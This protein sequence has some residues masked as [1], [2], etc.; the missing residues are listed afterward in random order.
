MTASIALDHAT[1]KE[2]H[3]LEFPGSFFEGGRN[4]M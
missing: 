3:T 2:P 4:P 1:D